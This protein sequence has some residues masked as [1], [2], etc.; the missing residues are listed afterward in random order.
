MVGQAQVI[1]AA[2]RNKVAAVAANVNRVDPL[3]L[4][5]GAPEST[6]AELVKLSDCEPVERFGGHANF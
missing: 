5:H 4:Q 3:R 6:G 2:E 1:V